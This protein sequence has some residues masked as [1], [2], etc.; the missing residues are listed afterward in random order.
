MPKTGGTSIR[1]MLNTA[2]SQKEILPN[3]REMK[4]YNGYP[5]IDK[6]LAVDKNIL[7]HKRLARG[8]YPFV[9]ANTLMPESRKIVFLRSPVE[10][11]VSFLHHMQR[12]SPEQSIESILESKIRKVANRQ[13]QFFADNELGC[14]VFKSGVVTE[15][16]LQMALC[17][18]EKCWFVGISERFDESMNLCQNML[19]IN[20]DNTV[21]RNQ[22]N[23]Q[24]TQLSDELME[25]IKQLNQFDL[26]FY[27]TALSRFNK[28]ID[29][30]RSND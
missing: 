25:R 26:I 30:S 29:L 12:R 24:K 14:Q 20:F 8:H 2:F 16:H 1:Q 7:E 13:V 3:R 9:V 10:R 6:L 4:K 21:T 28:R 5:S 19:G 22:G 23:Y 17:N 27:N 18:L 15:D 11:T